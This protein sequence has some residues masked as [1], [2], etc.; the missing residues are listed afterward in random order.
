MAQ[1]H[2]P[3]AP[4]IAA[5]GSLAA[6]VSCCLPAGTFLVASGAAGA[7][8]IVNPL[9]PWL[10]GVAIVALILGFVQAYGRSQCSLRRN[11]VSIVLLWT[12]ATLVLL[13]LLF[14]QA[15]A[16]FLADRLPSGAVR[17]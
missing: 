6:A 1:G 10:F 5:L 4:S 7:A 14:P 13:M 3:V 2:G 16:G 9:R 11:P 15:I 12:S 17:K 8:R